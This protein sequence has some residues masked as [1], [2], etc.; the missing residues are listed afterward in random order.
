MLVNLERWRWMPERLGTTRIWN[1]LPEF[2]TRVFK[3]ETLIHE[4]RLV[5]GTA[6]SQTPVFSDVVSHVIFQPEWGVPESIKIAQLLPHLKSGDIEVLDRRDMKVLDDRGKKMDP[7]RIRWEKADIRK[8][9]IVQNSGPGNPLGR[10]K[11][12]FPNAH[13]VYMHDTPDKALFN[14]EERTYSH[15]CM[16]LRNPDRYAEVLLGLDQGWTA[17]DVK[18]QLAS[19][20]RPRSI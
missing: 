17:A 2:K 15:G 8:V 7:M 9:S 10:L 1:N 6:K 16:R 20:N 18:R 3:D 19:K 11:F 13:Q 4:E 12:I 5:I 14:T